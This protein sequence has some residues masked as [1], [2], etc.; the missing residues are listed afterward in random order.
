MIAKLNMNKV[1]RQIEN[2][3]G[4]LFG[5]LPRPEKWVFI[6][7][8]YNSG[9][10]L[11]HDLLAS[12]P[13]VGS[14]PGE[15]QVYTDELKSPKSI[16]L[17]RLWAIEPDR[18][19]LD[20]NS[21]AEINVTRL[22]RQWGAR[23]ND[24][25]KPI[26][27]EK[28]PTNAA[29]VRWLQKNFD[30]SYFIGIVRNGYA[31]AEGIRRKAGHSLELSARQWLVSN[32]IMLRDFESLKHKRTITYEEL[33]GDPVETLGQV[34]GFLALDAAHSQSAAN[35]AWHIHEQVSTI[36]NMNGRS[37]AI[38]TSEEMETIGRIAGPM[39]SKFDYN[40]TE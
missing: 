4:G 8:C 30:D 19:Y 34:F 1:K 31:V 35:R 26:L 15:G 14:M 21:T 12:H 38:L 37:L 9:T 11:L 25:S 36:K 3:L 28:S 29:R 33:T 23:F 7:G 13:L 39:L 22:K 18:F 20:E 27:I 10:T 40:G 32:E 16:G 24:P 6:V 5:P 17:P 2:T